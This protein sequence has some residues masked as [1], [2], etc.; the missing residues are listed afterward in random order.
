MVQGSFL[1]FTI[2][3]SLYFS[4]LLDANMIL[5]LSESK[6][7]DACVGRISHHGESTK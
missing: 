3:P 2:P 4:F 7:Y 5:F 1:P 6:E